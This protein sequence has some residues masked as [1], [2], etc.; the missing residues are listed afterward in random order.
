[1]GKV[2]KD[3]F[4]FMEYV[5]SHL[6]RKID[7]IPE[8]K[9]ELITLSE[10]LSHFELSEYA[11]L[12]GAHLLEVSGVERTAEIEECFAANIRWQNKEAHFQEG[13]NAAGVLNALARD[14]K[15]PVKIKVL[16]VM[17]QVAATPHVRW[18]SLDASEYVVVVINLMFPKDL[19]KVREERETQIRLMR[20]NDAL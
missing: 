11:L 9:S 18:H 19:D 1:M 14:E 3:G 13:R 20:F 17:G 15:D 6:I 12:L 5:N 16:R 2:I 4:H 10:T 7:D 8:L